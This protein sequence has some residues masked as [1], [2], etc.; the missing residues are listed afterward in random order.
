MKTRIV[1]TAAVIERD[2]S[3]L[4]TR[5]LRGT[6][7]EG[8]WEFPGGKC[9]EGESLAESLAREIREELDAELVLGDEIFATLH[10]Y[11]D[12]IVEL[13]FFAGRLLNEPRPVLGQDMAWVAARDFAAYPMPP[14][15]DELIRLLREL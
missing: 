8:L 15:D 7:L 2:G 12:R 10:E 6:H 13:R 1:V 4:L 3:Y 14:A 11:D 5:R 9:E